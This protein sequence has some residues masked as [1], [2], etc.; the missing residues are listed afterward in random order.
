MWN[1]TIKAQVE[2]EEDDTDSDDEEEDKQKTA[3]ANKNLME[4]QTTQQAPAKQRK[5]QRKEQK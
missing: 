4:E 2:L 5:T 1:E 3:T